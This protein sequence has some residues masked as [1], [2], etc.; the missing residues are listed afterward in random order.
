[1]VGVSSFRSLDPEL[2]IELRFADR[3][4]RV[5]CRICGLLVYWSEIGSVWSA[6][7]RDCAAACGH[8]VWL[9]LGSSYPVADRI[10]LVQIVIDLVEAVACVELL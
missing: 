9:V 4:E 8:A 2:G 1:M 10:T 3:F 7:S 5:G 6:D